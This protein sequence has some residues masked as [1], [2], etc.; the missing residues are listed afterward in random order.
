[1]NETK[2]FGTIIDHENRIETL[3]TNWARIMTKEDFYAA[4]DKIMV[5]LNRLDQEHMITNHRLDRI[6]QRLRIR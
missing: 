4:F 6:E 5:I 1:M 2:L 3:E